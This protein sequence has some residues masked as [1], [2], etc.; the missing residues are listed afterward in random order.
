[1]LSI[2]ISTSAYAATPA[3]QTA[4]PAAVEKAI[5][6]VY[7]PD[8]KSEVT[9]TPMI[10]GVQCYN[11]RVEVPEGKANGQVTEYGD[12]IYAAHP[13]AANQSVPA[14]IQSTLQDLFKNVPEHWDVQTQPVYEAF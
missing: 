7:G 13:A 4:P 1:L 11:I 9:G 14:A 5:H 2:V 8:V 12:F 3:A 10:N 6:N